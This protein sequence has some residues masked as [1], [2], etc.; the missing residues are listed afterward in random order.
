MFLYFVILHCLGRPPRA[1]GGARRR[2]IVTGIN[3][4]TERVKVNGVKFWGVS[5]RALESLEEF[6]EKVNG[7]TPHGKTIS[8]KMGGRF[9]N[10]VALEDTESIV[11]SCMLPVD[12]V[13]SQE[14][15][16]PYKHSIPRPTNRSLRPIDGGNPDFPGLELNE[17][18]VDRIS[19]SK[20]GC[21]PNTASHMPVESGISQADLVID[22]QFTP[23][24][25]LMSSADSKSLPWIEPHGDC[26]DQA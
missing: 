15:Y 14:P 1:C 10:E 12:N 17:K 4:D 22:T 5:F 18:S 13:A 19:T 16:R 26:N 2:W 24:N 3:A 9:R 23:Y 21:H 20:S 11:T 25:F 6:V 7:S 8:V